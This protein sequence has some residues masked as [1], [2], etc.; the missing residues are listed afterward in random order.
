MV[1]AEMIDIVI[2]K[3]YLLNSNIFWSSTF[4]KEL[5]QTLRGLKGINLNFNMRLL[6][7]YADDHTT[8][9]TEM[10]KNILSRSYNHWLG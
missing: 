4:H 5:W 2:F 7:L 9:I 1:N 8:T 10:S 3:F 6:N